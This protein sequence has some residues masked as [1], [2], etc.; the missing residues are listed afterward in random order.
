VEVKKMKK[1]TAL[2]VAAALL[3]SLT[4]CSLTFL[5]REVKVEGGKEPSPTDG[6]EPEEPAPGPAPSET[7]DAPDEE[8]DDTPATLLPDPD[9]EDGDIDDPPSKT[10]E[11]EEEE[12]IIRISHTDVTLKR[13]GETFRLSVWDSE[14]KDPDVCAFTSDDPAIASVDEDGG[15]VTA[16]APGT[17]KITAHVQFGSETQDL[18]CIVR[19][20][21]KAADAEEPEASQPVSGTDAPSLSSFFSTLQG[22]YEGLNNMMVLDDSLLDVYYP[23]LS[24]VP[25]VEEVLVQETAIS[26]SNM[27]VGLVKLSDSATMED[28]VAVQSAL[29][30]RID[31]QA[32]GGAFYPASCDTWKAGVITSVSNCVGMFVYPDEAQ[33]M[34]DLFVLTYAS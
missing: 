10:E 3:L 34:A 9:K 33:S 15:E 2:L 19:C 31:A 32:D 12:Y 1:W 22:K 24:S 8:S 16:V 30:S 23:G 27:A 5:N 4:A 18:T 26:I 6:V 25:N 14:G 17:T 21:W 11:T 7:P 28:I 29:Q 20:S 13:E